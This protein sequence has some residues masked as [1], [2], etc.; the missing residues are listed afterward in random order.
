MN[1]ERNESMDKLLYEMYR[2][3]VGCANGLPNFIVGQKEDVPYDI[4][5]LA[6]GYCKAIDT[7]N[8]LKKNQYFSAL[9]I[10]YWHL[11]PYLYEKSKTLGIQ[12]YDVYSWLVQGIQKA[13]K[14]RGWLDSKQKVY[15]D[16]RGAEKCINQCITSVRGNYFVENNRYKRDYCKSGYALVFLDETTDEE[17]ALTYGDF[18]SYD[19]MPE[20]FKTDIY[21]LMTYLSKHQRFMDM[22]VLDFIIENNFMVNR[23]GLVDAVK[24]INIDFIRK[25]NDKYSLNRDDSF[26]EMCLRLKEKT[27]SYLT[28]LVKSALITLS[29]DELLKEALTM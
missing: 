12:I 2:G 29:R 6:N 15:N 13:M 19:M 16:P 9:M 20:T 23:S 8:S 26:T 24:N 7:N 17:E 22:L 14:Y 18:V 10:R 5:E 11:I 27:S 21:D 25:F 4:N 1:E 28:S 3:L